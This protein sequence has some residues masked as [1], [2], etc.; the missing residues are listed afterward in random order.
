MEFGNPHPTIYIQNLNEKVSLPSLRNTLLE[1]F[2]P[3][4][5]VEDV[6][7]K[8][9]LALRGQAWVRF[10]TAE[11]ALKALQGMQGKRLFGKSMVIRFAKFKSDMVSKADGTFEVEKYHRDQDKLER[12]RNPRLTRR[13]IM[14]QLQANPTMAVMGSATMAP[15]ALPMGVGSDMQLPNKILFLTA[16]P[17]GTTEDALTSLFQK[18]T[19][20]VEIRLVPGRPDL[21][22]VEY[23]SEGQAAMAKNV[24]D[25]HEIAPGIPL[26][27]SFARR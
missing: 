3:F 5:R 16:L 4:G 11:A 24:L 15:T 23:E 27:V 25:K 2:A 20:F 17:V 26:R 21:A 14:Q 1:W 12:A 6:I 8:K 18:H 7:A 22:F 19:G 10:D 9:R 13:Q